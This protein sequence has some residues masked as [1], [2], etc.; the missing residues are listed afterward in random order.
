MAAP[1]AKLAELSDPDRMIAFEQSWEEGRLKARMRELP[2]GHPLRWPALVEMVKID[3]ERQ[4][5][6]GRRPRLEGYLQY[7]PE[8]GTHD[9]V[10]ADLLQAEYEVRQQFGDPVELA[11]YERRFPRQA[12]RLHELIRQARDEASAPRL[13]HPNR[14]TPPPVASTPS[15]SLAGVAAGALPE[16]FGKYQII[17]KLGQGGMGTV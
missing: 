10:P 11:E 3:L 7:Y 16:H 8:L 5:R 9:I 4:W 15:L 17:T 1:N 12:G 13:A 14:E 2:P 6:L